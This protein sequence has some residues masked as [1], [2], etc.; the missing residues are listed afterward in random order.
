MTDRQRI[1]FYFPAW[2]KAWK[3]NWTTSKGRVN[4]APGRVPCLIVEIQGEAPVDY[5]ARI[6]ELAARRSL[7]KG[8]PPGAEDYRHACHLFALGKDKSS[9]HLTNS[10]VERCVYLFRL[11]ADPDDLDA[12]LGWLH[13]ENDT[14][15]R[16]LWFLEHRCQLPFVQRVCHDKFATYDFHS[17]NLDSIQDLVRT[18][19]NR[20]H[21]QTGGASVPASRPTDDEYAD[22]AATEDDNEP[23]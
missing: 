15:K 17:L 4:P 7:K 16:L 2:N 12:I 13:P 20:P 10:E 22:Q 1:R 21:G 11:L 8:K 9:E 6:E 5:L 18:M 14:R 3:M 23:F 19:K